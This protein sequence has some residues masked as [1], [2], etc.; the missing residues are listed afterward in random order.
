MKLRSTSHV[1]Y[2]CAYH[3]VWIPKYRRNILVVEVAEYT[4][5]VLKEIA[6]ELGCEVLALEVMPDHVHVFLLCPPRLAPSY[7]ANYLKGKSARKVLQKFPELKSKSKYGKLWTRSY[8][9][10]TVGN[11]T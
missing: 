3:F 6:E 8:F 4:K 10:A 9:V 5:E 1:K 11:V 7:I 2:W